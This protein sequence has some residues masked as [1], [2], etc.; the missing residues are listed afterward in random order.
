MVLRVF[1]DKV[2]WGRPLPYRRQARSGTQFP[3]VES[4]AW[5]PPARLL[6]LI[7]WRR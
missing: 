4:L 7:F 2:S 3:S 6:S 1:E 5:L